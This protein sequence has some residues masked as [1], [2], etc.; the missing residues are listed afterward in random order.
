MRIYQAT[1]FMGNEFKNFREEFVIR[2][3]VFTVYDHKRNGKVERLIRT[4]NE[5]LTASS[6][7][8]AEKQNKYFYQ[9]ENALRTSKGKDGKSPF[10]RHTS[11]KPNTV[12]SIIVKLF[13]ELND[14]D[15]DKSVESD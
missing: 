4:V 2:H 5:G 3:I 10:E 9:L 13:E 6:E 14:L 8:L 1:V 15:Y 7:M 12:T 11:R